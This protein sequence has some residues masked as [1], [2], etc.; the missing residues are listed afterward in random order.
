MEDSNKFT[1]YCMTTTPQVLKSLCVP[2]LQRKNRVHANVCG[3]LSP[4]S[5]CRERF[6]C[7]TQQTIK[8]LKENKLNLNV[9]GSS[10]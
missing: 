8:K 3:M 5:A 10:Q 7:N 6:S 2:M 9:Q 1:K 4:H